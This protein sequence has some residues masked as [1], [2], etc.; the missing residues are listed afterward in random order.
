MSRGTISVFVD[1]CGQF[2]I[3]RNTACF[4]AEENPRFQARNTCKVAV[5]LAEMTRVMRED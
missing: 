3:F 2:L 1:I 4:W 5:F